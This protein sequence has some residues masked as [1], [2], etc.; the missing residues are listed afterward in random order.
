MAYKRSL[1]VSVN[2]ILNFNDNI[3]GC[4]ITCGRSRVEI[5]EMVAVSAGTLLV[6]FS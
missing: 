1:R 6:F 3:I 5:A 2:Y 4:S